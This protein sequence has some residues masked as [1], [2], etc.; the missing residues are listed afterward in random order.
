MKE[1]AFSTHETSGGHL[2]EV[3]SLKITHTRHANVL[4]RLYVYIYV[5]NNNNNNNNSNN[6]HHH[7]HLEKEL[8][9]LKVIWSMKVIGRRGQWR[10]C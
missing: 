9:N 5:Y 2:K 7:H 4:G 10:S 1:L 6:H 3:V 8:T